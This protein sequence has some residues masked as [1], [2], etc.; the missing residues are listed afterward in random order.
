MVLSGFDFFPIKLSV[1]VAFVATFFV[2]I[3]G[4]ALAYL[5]ATKKFRGKTFLEVL[6][7][8]PLILPPTVTGYYLI[9]LFGRQGMIG[10]FFDWNLTFTWGAAVIASFVVALPL[11]VRTAQAAIESVDRSMINTSYML[12]YGRWQTAMK[13]IFPLSK[14]GLIA[15]AILSFARAMGEFGATLMFAGNIPGRTNTMPL[16]IYS[17]ASSGEWGKAHLLVLILTIGSI[18]ILMLATK[19]AQKD[20]S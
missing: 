2:V 18:L 6:I 4:T 5:L 12:G 7:T 15:G 9:L 11:M 3:I 1:Q 17:L 16:E 8:L 14:K 10:K 19:L 20:W 13:V